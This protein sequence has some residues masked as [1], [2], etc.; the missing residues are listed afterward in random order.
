MGSELVNIL[1]Q[2]KKNDFFVLVQLSSIENPKNISVLSF[3]D[4]VFTPQEQ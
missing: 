2:L 4:S 1:S 3:Y